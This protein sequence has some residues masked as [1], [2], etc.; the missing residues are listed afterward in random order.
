MQQRVGLPP[1]ARR[2]LVFGQSGSGKTTLG[3][4]IGEALGVP[5]IELDSLY[6]QP[7]W[8]PTPDDEFV[9]QVAS[10]L[11]AHSEGWVVEGNYKVIRPV[12]LPRADAIVRLRLPFRTVYP[13]L[14]WRTLSRSW[15][16]QELWNGNRE[17]FRLAFTSRESILLW[18]IS[19]WRAHARSLDEALRTIPHTAPVIELR[20]ARE[21]RAFVEGLI[22]R[23]AS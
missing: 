17:S 23:G 16:R 4:A 6:H 3:L 1:E 8:V 14:V 10:L 2:I 12:T 5:H 13:R 11:D 15:R 9:A 20:S 21:V 7:N 22:A 18:G 19:H